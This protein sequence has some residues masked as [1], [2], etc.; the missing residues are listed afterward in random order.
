M[1]RSEGNNAMKNNYRITKPLLVA[2]LV[3]FASGSAAARDPLPSW[4]DGPTKKAILEF[5]AAVTDEG[6]K[7]YVEPAERIA[8]FDND[9]TLWVEYP[10]YTQALFA[11]DRVKKLAP[12]HPEWKTQQ[13]FKGV[14]EDDMKAVGASGMKGL[15][16]IIMATHSGMTAAEFD[17][18]VS[19][20]LATT[21]QSRFKRLYT[22]LIYQPQL[23]LLAYLRANGF[24]T[25]IVSGGGMAFM[26]PITE[27][28]YGI[29]PEQVVGSSVV[30]EFQVKDGKPVLVR[31]PK[32]DF[33]NDKAGKPV[34][35]YEHIGRRPILAFGNSDSDMQ[36]IQYTKAGDG[37]RLG[38]FVHHTDADREYAYDRDSH[39]GTL[40]KVLDMAADNDWIIVS[41]K[42]D[43]KKVFPGR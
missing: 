40:D 42:N 41:M 22:E 16:E 12:Q 19:G 32:I 11:F 35:I 29:P 3:A 14:L 28:A 6:G 5:V 1:Q 31:M 23:E 17:Q 7:D 43:W 34:G 26:R 4:N 20:W 8:V 27:K 10:M 25:F 21:K 33:I 39:V 38:L 36:M 9:G 13:P 30:A 24:K 15:M 37:R 18:E 2:L